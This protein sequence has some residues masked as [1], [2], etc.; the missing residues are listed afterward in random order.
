M[1]A[2]YRRF[3]DPDSFPSEVIPLLLPALRY[4]LELRQGVVHVIAKAATIASPK[5]TEFLTTR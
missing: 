5:I 1:K 2:M 4:D 3:P